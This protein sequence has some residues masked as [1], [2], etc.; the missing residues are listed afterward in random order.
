MLSLFIWYWAKAKAR[1][2][3]NCVH[4]YG[5]DRYHQV[6]RRYAGRTIY[7]ISDTNLALKN[8]IYSDEPFM[9]ARFGANEICAMAVY[10]FHINSKMDKITFEL[11]KGAGFFI[12]SENDME[13]FSRLMKESCSYIDYLAIWYK[14]FEAYYIRTKMRKDIILSWLRHFEP[15]YS[16]EPWTKALSG[17]RVLVIHP[18]T[19]TIRSQ[20]ARRTKLFANQD[21]LPEFE[22]HTLKAVQTI[23]WQKD[24]RF[25]NWF[26]A[27]EY[28]YEEAMKT[29][30]DIALIGCGAYGF[31]LAA[32]LK[33][34]GKQAVHMGGM[35][36]ILFGIK[37][38]RWDQDAKVSLLYNKYWVSPSESEIPEKASVVE[39]GCYW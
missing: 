3:S 9:A 36:Q 39:N 37:G 30:F 14:P 20:Y 28:M 12:Q 31:P 22:L 11:C 10:D 26:E 25:Q 5:T 4:K 32:K 27:L 18:F 6:K 16:D 15:W 35:L 19:D 17:K 2:L 23:A 7:N 24:S 1:L 33:A 34:A 13:D 21:M 8:L 29:E 38:K